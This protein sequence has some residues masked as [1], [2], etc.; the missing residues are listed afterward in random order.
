MV[1]PLLIK[2]ATGILRSKK[3]LMLIGILFVLLLFKRSIKK[4]IRAYR[5]RRFDKS[6][7]DTIN[8][9]AQQY[10]A[11][12]NPSGLSWMID[13]DG[14]DEQLIDRLAYQSKGEYDAIS[15]AYRDKFDESL[16]D[17]M[18]KELGSEEFMQFRNIID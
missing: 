14:T 1:N 3:F 9:L 5:E 2:S 13:V 11:A 12:S 18:R 10:R 6:E 7:A 16:T 4:A 15:D 17:R 8:Q